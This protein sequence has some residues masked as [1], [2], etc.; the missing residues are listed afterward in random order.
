MK[1]CFFQLKSLISVY[2]LKVNLIDLFITNFY[3]IF[4]VFFLQYFDRHEFGSHHQIRVFQRVF[5]ECDDILL[6][7]KFGKY[8]QPKYQAHSKRI[9]IN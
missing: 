8:L 9:A 4:S 5:F 1:I 3:V 2:I 7:Q 6:T